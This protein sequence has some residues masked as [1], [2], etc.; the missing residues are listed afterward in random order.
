MQANE[1]R[2]DYNI[3]I[4]PPEQWPVGSMYKICKIHNYKCLDTNYNAN[5]ALLQTQSTPIYAVLPSPATVLFNRPISG[6]L[7]KLTREPINIYYS[8]AQYEALK[9]CQDKFFKDSD[10]HKDSLSFPLG[11]CS[12]KM[13][14]PWTPGVIEAATNSN[15][16]GRSYILGVMKMERMIIWKTKH[17]C[18]APINTEQYLQE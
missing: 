13:G 7:P 14:G 3:T 8:D 11:S 17:I 4:S 9:L 16:R 1:H 2:T 18:S 5:L 10:T 6:L 15:H 12:L